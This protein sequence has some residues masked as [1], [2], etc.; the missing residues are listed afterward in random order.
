MT[1]RVR[2]N[3]GDI[4]SVPLEDG[5]TGYVQYLANDT[6]MLGGDVLRVFETHYD[7]SD[8]PALAEIIAG[9]VQFYT[10]V[11][12]NAALKFFEWEKVGSAKFPDR[13]DV[14]F[15]SSADNGNPDMR[16]SKKW[17]IWKINEPQKFIG[18]LS[19]E[20]QSAEI[21]MVMAPQNIANRMLTGSYGIVYPGYE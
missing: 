14:L 18:T 15:R 3:L 6:T 21:G 11:F 20:Y 7:V 9:P 19:P 2:R 12:L 16:V 17:Y 4:F 8:V 10:H 5:K 13:V 1:K